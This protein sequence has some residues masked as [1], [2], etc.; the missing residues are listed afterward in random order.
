MQPNYVALLMTALVLRS[1]NSVMPFIRVTTGNYIY[2]LHATF[3]FKKTLV[4]T[5]YVKSR[6][7]L[8]S[9][10]TRSCYL[11]ITF[12]SDEYFLVTFAGL[13]CSSLFL[14]ASAP[15]KSCNRHG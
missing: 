3:I 12:D 1:L 14:P 6:T 10:R 4:V 9:Y 5:L 11:Q 15:R 2:S 7:L 13:Y 8:E